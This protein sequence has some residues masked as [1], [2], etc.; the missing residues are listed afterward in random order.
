MKRALF[1]VLLLILPAAAQERV[2]DAFILAQLKQGRQRRKFAAEQAARFDGTVSGPDRV[3][4]A[5]L[6]YWANNWA[7]TAD[8]FGA[9]LAETKDE[10]EI[11]AKAMLHHTHALV[12]AKHWPQVPG[13]A[14]AYFVEFP[15]QEHTAR[16]R[17][18]EG[19][20]L[21]VIGKL[22]GAREAFR[23]GAQKGH[24]LCS[25]E[26][27]DCLVQLGRY[28]EALAVAESNRARSPRFEGLLR[29]LPNLGKKLPTL[30]FDHW[31]GKR[32]VMSEIR[33]RPAVFAFWLTRATTAN[34]VTH[35]LMNGWAQAN[36]GKLHVVGATI[37]TKFD[38]HEMRLKPDM[39]VQEERDWIWQWFEEYNLNYPLVLLSKN[40]LHDLCGIPA[41]TPTLP[42]FALTDRK[43]RLRYVRVGA[44]AW[45]IEATEAMLQR[46]VAES[47]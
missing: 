25:Y 10:P 7:K 22:E 17:F 1:A 37:Y 47:N 31:T 46:L 23:K 29:A 36:K 4:L 2:R 12:E 6:W 11:R 39:T 13:A 33:A 38:P 30:P 27:A 24:D 28:D 26:E 43:G 35:R 45:A 21:R 5:Y 3:Y 15:G 19:R 34:D 41:V 14:K 40:T 18:Y 44:S 9:W 16:I 42:A 8:A 32:I 20:A